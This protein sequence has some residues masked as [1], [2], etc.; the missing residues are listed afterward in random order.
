[1]KRDRLFRAASD[2]GASSP[3]AALLGTAAASPAHEAA[4]RC[5]IQTIP[6]ASSPIA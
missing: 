2:L 3:A 6:T 5:G 1:M 4:D